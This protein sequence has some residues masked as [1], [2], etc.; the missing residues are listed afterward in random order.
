MIQMYGVSKIYNSEIKALQGINL[1]I[2]RGEFVCLVGPSGAGKTTML[3]LI[4]G[5]EK[6]TSG[7]IYVDGHDM[8]YISKREISLLRRK[9]GFVFQDFKL[10]KTK[11][12]FE[13]IAFV[14]KVIGVKEQE[15]KRRVADVLNLVELLNKSSSFPHQLSCGEQQRV[16]IARALVNNPVLLLADEPTG[17]L[18]LDI[19]KEIIYLLLQA[20]ER[21]TTVILATHNNHLATTLKKRIIYLDKG[22]IGS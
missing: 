21:N 4:T 5:F 19:A 2:E 7:A 8:N 22:K 1:S 11:T 15:I 16:A 18:D 20:N 6:S 10:I 14:L 17:N 9:M 3:R 12:V 13:N